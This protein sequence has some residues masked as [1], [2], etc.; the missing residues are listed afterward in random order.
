VIY[1]ELLTQPVNPQS[2]SVNARYYNSY[3]SSD[4]FTTMGVRDY[5]AFMQPLGFNFVTVSGLQAQF[6]SESGTS[7]AID[8]Y[9]NSDQPEDFT[10][11]PNTMY[12]IQGVSS[13][14]YGSIGF[15]PNRAIQSLVASV[16]VPVQIGGQKFQI[17]GALTFNDDGT[18][19]SALF[20]DDVKYSW[21]GQ[22]TEL[23]GS[24]HFYPNGVPSEFQPSSDSLM[25]FP[26]YGGS[27]QPRSN[28]TIDLYPSG[29]LKTVACNDEKLELSSDLYDFTGVNQV[30]FFQDGFPSDVNLDTGWV[31]LNGDQIHFTHFGYGVPDISFYPDHSIKDFSDV[32]DSIT[33][34]VQNHSFDVDGFISFN[35]DNS[36]E[37][38]FFS[39]PGLFGSKTITFSVGGQN[40]AFRRDS[41][42]DVVMDIEFYPGGI[43]K[44]GTLAQDAT[45]QSAEEA[46]ISF[47]SGDSVK[48]DLNGRCLQS[49]QN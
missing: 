14:I 48:F 23:S 4:K 24:V 40:V 22:T 45:F 33:V 28:C 20:G 9:K 42:N 47:K 13:A 16:P 41:T 35:E 12:P 36:F 39:K 5:I 10:V 21:L 46:S 38:G 3:L 43:L 7:A 32:K 15:Y 44:S 17:D 25:T 11:G 29:I 31:M 8:F 6:Y 1:D 34:S 26:I 18:I 37:S 49:T 2:N 19:E 27:I 30:S